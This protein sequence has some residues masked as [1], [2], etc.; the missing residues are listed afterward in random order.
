MKGNVINVEKP[1]FIIVHGDKK[2]KKNVYVIRHPETEWNKIGKLQGHKDSQLTK[3]GI[4][5]VGAIDI[6]LLDFYF[7][8]I[9]LIFL[10]YSLFVFFYPLI[11]CHFLT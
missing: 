6:N 1:L 10:I 11:C 9:F 2:M 8:G 4:E 3:K 5:I 7:F